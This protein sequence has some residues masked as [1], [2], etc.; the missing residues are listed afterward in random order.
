MVLFFKEC[1]FI[2][3]SFS[4]NNSVIITKREIRNILSQLS[5]APAISSQQ[6]PKKHCNFHRNFLEPPRKISKFR[7]QLS[8]KRPAKSWGDCI[9][10]WWAHVMGL[11]KYPAFSQVIRGA[12]SIFHGPLAELVSA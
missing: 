6:T 4:T 10:K 2:I 8:Q 3:F 11:G 5:L 1:L 9:V 12:L 7:P